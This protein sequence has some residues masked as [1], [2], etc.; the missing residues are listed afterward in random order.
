MMPFIAKRHYKALSAPL[1]QIQQIKKKKKVRRGKGYGIQAK[2][3]KIGLKKEIQFNR[4]GN[5]S[6]EKYVSVE[7]V[8]KK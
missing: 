8:L 1:V 6:K 7:N 3:K 2:K 4:E 5:V